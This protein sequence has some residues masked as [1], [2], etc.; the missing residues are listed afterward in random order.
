[1]NLRKI[2]HSYSSV[3]IYLLN[4]GISAKLSDE[5]K[6]QAGKLEFLRVNQFF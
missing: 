6:K 1:M 2:F 3:F 4:I 5:M